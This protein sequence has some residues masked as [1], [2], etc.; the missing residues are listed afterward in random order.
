MKSHPGLLPQGYKVESKIRAK[1]KRGQCKM[2]DPTL[3]KYQRS[4]LIY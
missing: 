1:I 3:D 4:Y 2:K